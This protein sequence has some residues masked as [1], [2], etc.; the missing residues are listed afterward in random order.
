MISKLVKKGKHKVQKVI[1]Q[2]P[3]TKTFES[4]S[5]VRFLKKSSSANKIFVIIDARNPNS[6]RYVPYEDSV[7]EKVVLVLNKIDLVPREVAIGWYRFL[8]DTSQV[9]ALSANTESTALQNFT[10]YVKS[11]NISEI[12]I[13]GVG[14]VGKKTLGNALRNIDGLTINLETWTWLQ[15]TPDLAVLKAVE[16]MPSGCDLIFG[17][18]DIIRRSSIQSLMEVFRITFFSDPDRL[19]QTINKQPQTAAI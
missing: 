5:F 19:L 8:K 13:T 3:N 11:L 7:K 12:L 9:F 1:D 2:R 6:C 17:V 18:Y 14:N 16:K 15:P 4:D 10:E